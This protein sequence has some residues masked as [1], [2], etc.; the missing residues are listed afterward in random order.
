MSR[1]RDCL[2]TKLQCLLIKTRA[3]EVLTQASRLFFSD[4]FLRKWTRGREEKETR[5]ARARGLAQAL[6]YAKQAY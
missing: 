6:F 2:V 3:S 4:R 1:G 5:E